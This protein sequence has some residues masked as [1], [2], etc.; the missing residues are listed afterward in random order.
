M[1]IK[2]P[3]LV[4]HILG[5]IKS[6]VMRLFQYYG[7]ASTLADESDPQLSIAKSPSRYDYVLTRDFEITTDKGNIYK[8]DPMLVNSQPVELEIDNV[9][10]KSTKSNAQPI[11]T[12]DGSKSITHFIADR[13]GIF[14]GLPYKG[15]L[16]L[17]TVSAEVAGDGFDTDLL[18]QQDVY[19]PVKG[20]SLLSKSMINVFD[21]KGGPTLYSVSLY[22]STNSALKL[23]VH[24]SDPYDQ[25]KPTSYVLN[26]SLPNGVTKADGAVMAVSNSDNF[27]VDSK[28]NLLVYFPGNKNSLFC[29]N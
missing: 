16:N 5:S 26:A 17:A 9:D 15:I 11:S 18:A 3:Y 28:I 24:S 21:S 20:D 13:S 8:Q 14:I 29:C 25:T 2:A 6:Y 1:L 22:S 19:T 27:L 10:N 7:S 23:V 4:M 12:F